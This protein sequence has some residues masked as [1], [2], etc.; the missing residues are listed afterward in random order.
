[1]K[2][3]DLIQR[4]TA[5]MSNMVTFDEDGEPRVSPELE[6]LLKDIAEAQSAG[7]VDADLLREM[8]ETLELMKTSMANP[9]IARSMA[10]ALSKEHEPQPVIFDAIE[11]QDLDAVR[12]ELKTWDVNQTFGEY[13][14]TALYHAMSCMFGISLDV[15]NLLL[16]AGA[17]PQKGLTDSNVLHG[18]GFADLSEIRAED[19]AVVVQRCVAL[20]AD[21]E[22]RTNRLQW[23][24]L[25]TA[26]S[27]WNPVACEALL[28]SGADIT[29]RAG[30]V[31]GVCYAGADSLAFADGHAETMAVFKRFLT[32]SSSN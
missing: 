12:L 17:D 1:M 23:T 14:C 8:A 13:D 2:Q 3:S 32:P 5:L 18:L 22:Q 15:I 4:A 7:S 11:D 26:A 21:M 19:L 16:D 25:I 31:E 29:A 24:P 30:D 10:E 9:E 27:E 28:L 20:G 6:P